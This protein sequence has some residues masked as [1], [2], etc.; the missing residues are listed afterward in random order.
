MCVGHIVHA[1]LLT[2]W[3]EN[4][5]DMNGLQVLHFCCR[6]LEVEMNIDEV[7]IKLLM[8]LKCMLG[9]GCCFGCNSMAVFGSTSLH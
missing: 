1:D 5:W 3:R 6:D 7:W 8:Q 4:R 9:H 2:S